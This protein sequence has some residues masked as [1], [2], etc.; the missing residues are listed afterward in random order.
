MAAYVGP[1][2]PFGPRNISVYTVQYLLQLCVMINSGYVE[3]LTTALVAK[4]KI[5]TH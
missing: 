1:F 3:S 2:K 5:W 4:I